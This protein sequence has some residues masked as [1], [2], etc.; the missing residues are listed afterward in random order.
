MLTMLSVHCLWFW[1]LPDAVRWLPFCRSAGRTPLHPV[2]QGGAMLLDRPS[3]RHSP[4]D[5]DCRITSCTAERIVCNRRRVMG[6]RPAA[7]RVVRPGRGAGCAAAAALDGTG[8]HRAAPWPMA[9]RGNR[10][11]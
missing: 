10:F 11:T 3:H 5:P 9:V 7:S 1:P 2:W 4:D 6:I 8:H